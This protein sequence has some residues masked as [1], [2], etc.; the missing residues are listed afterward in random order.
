MVR[1]FA[2]WE[3]DLPALQYRFTGEREAL[4]ASLVPSG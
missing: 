4:A 1:T 3:D 2:Q